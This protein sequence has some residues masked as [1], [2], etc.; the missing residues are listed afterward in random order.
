M[1]KDCFTCKHEDKNINED[2]CKLCCSSKSYPYE[3][4]EAKE[5][6]GEES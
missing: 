2:P 5:E 1:I 3:Y 6:K 4:W